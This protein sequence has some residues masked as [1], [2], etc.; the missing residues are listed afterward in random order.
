MDWLETYTR[1]HLLIFQTYPKTETRTRFYAPT[2]GQLLLDG[3]DIKA[4]DP[5]LLT[6]EIAL[7]GQVSWVEIARVFLDS[8]CWRWGCVWV[9]RCGH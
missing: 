4:L 3:T 6:K 7:V 9:D 5:E 2:E 1:T 8:G